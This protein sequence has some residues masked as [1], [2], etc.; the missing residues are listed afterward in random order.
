MGLLVDDKLIV[1][2]PAGYNFAVSV[3]DDSLESDFRKCL[4]FEDLGASS[5]LPRP[6]CAGASIR[7]IF[8][9]PR[10][11]GSFIRFSTSSSWP[12]LTMSTTEAAFV[13]HVPVRA[14]SLVQRGDILGG[15]VELPQPI[16]PRFRRFSLKTR[17]DTRAD[18]VSSV[19]N[20]RI[21]FEPVQLT[22]A[23]VISSRMAGLTTTSANLSSCA[24]EVT[25]GLQLLKQVLVI[26]DKVSRIVLAATF[27]AG[28]T[29]SVLLKGV[30]NPKVTG[31]L[32]WT[33][34]SFKQPRIKGKLVT[35]AEAAGGPTNAAVAAGQVATRATLG[36][37][38]ASQGLRPHEQPPEVV[39]RWLDWEAQG[40]D[41]ILE[42]PAP[43]IRGLVRMVP[44][45]A[46][47]ES[48]F[49]DFPDTEVSFTIALLPG[50]A[51]K[52]QR[53]LI[54]APE[55]WNLHD[56][57]F[58]R[59][60]SLPAVKDLGKMRCRSGIAASGG[61]WLELYAA[62][63]E[64]DLLGQVRC[65]FNVAAW[66]PNE[67]GF[68]LNAA[69][70]AT[71]GDL[72]RWLLESNQ[73]W[74]IQIDDFQGPDCGPEPDKLDPSLVR[75]TNDA[76]FTGF[77]LK[78]SLG[79]LR[80]VPEPR[81]MLPRMITT[82][83]IEFET[84]SEMQLA[85]PR[86]TERALYLRLDAPVGIEF[87]SGCLAAVPD[88]DYSA[89][90]GDG[91]LA[92]V[93]VREAS[94][95]TGEHRLVLIGTNPVRTPEKN[96]W[97]LESFVDATYEMVLA[98][99]FEDVRQR[100]RTHGFSLSQTL[101]ARVRPGT[102]E[103]GAT[104]LFLWFRPAVY[105][106]SKGFLE[107]HAAQGFEVSCE[108]TFV[109]LSMPPGNCRAYHASSGLEYS[110]NHDVVE[111]QLN[112]GFFLLPNNDYELAL[113]ASNPATQSNMDL[114]SWGFLL[115]D[116][117]R[118]VLEAN[119]EIPTY[120]LTGTGLSVLSLQPSTSV[121]YAR[122]EVRLLVQFSKRLVL[123]FISE[124]R[125]EAPA[126]W[127]FQPMCTLYK[128][129][130]GGCESLCSFQLPYAEDRG[131]HLCPH[132]NVL[133]LLLD[134]EAVIEPGVFVLLLGVINP[135][136][137]PSKNFWSVSLLTPA[138]VFGWTPENAEAMFQN[139]LRVGQS[140]ITDVSTTGFSVG[141]RQ[142]SLPAL[143]LKGE[144]FEVLNMMEGFS[145]RRTPLSAWTLALA[146]LALGACSQ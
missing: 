107:I 95:A 58:V 103:P 78:E 112:E 7:F 97:T 81:G 34:R 117:S 63:L 35:A 57:T 70:P 86:G 42:Y 138:K 25:A 132:A 37:Q 72:S 59:G 49:F 64:E 38:A 50:Q 113:S 51:Y 48:G 116:L 115:R 91:H 26:K 68:S 62:R 84:R 4:A 145:S 129:V 13:A 74:L 126:G 46:H 128:D 118:T 87:A 30:K 101:Q 102:Q 140:I 85:L 114:R 20:I 1:T 40:R 83:A 99:N 137:A 52:G 36:T 67:V 143:P 28:I 15:R 54:F 111:F 77:E 80:V 142:P 69:T 104:Q 133:L 73:A 8:R 33:V 82:F 27:K 5:P 127:D 55:G 53:L 11:A 16:T 9:L 139:G 45:G 90:T 98:G 109:L 110:D 120:N 32:L 75:F 93:Q 130:T 94:L 96:W 144:R 3:A 14:S 71:P 124:V 61:A 125:I 39:L 100:G 123:K 17:L 29:Y 66:C 106:A 6:T 136:A 76:L 43:P 18:A 131:H 119:M 56:G 146:A 135:A 141:F 23:V 60:E 88:P 44:G 122:N 47:L 92:I 10:E 89:C 2:G 105:V 41:E 121:P 108:P 19:G 21:T 31:T 65:K 79:Q 134:Q 22:E 24:T 12:R